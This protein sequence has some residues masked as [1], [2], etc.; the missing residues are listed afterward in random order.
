MTR[1]KNSVYFSIK[2]EL[3]FKNQAISLVRGYG[4]ELQGQGLR[5]TLLQ[6]KSCCS[7]RVHTACIRQAQSTQGGPAVLGV[8][9]ARSMGAQPKLGAAAAREVHA[10]STA[11]GAGV[12]A[13]ALHGS[14]ASSPR[15]GRAAAG[16][17]WP[18]CRHRVNPEWLVHCCRDLA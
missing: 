12:A 7:L 1:V 9:R 18:R 17:G 3:S 10:G 5:H 11:Q 15:A 2:V 14:S 8:S 13:C 4:A 6:A 16:T